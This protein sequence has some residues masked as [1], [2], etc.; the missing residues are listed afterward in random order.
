MGLHREL[1]LFVEI[2]LTEMEALQAATNK[3]AESISL[4]QVGTIKKDYIADIVILEKNP[5]DNIENTKEIFKV[6]KGG[7]IYDQQAIL[8]TIPSKEYLEKEF[9]KFEKKFTMGS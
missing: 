2:R 5:L 4:E 9:K 7:K 1:E 3:A 6:I 8:R